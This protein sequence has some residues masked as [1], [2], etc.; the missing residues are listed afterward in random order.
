MPDVPRAGGHLF[1]GLVLRVKSCHLVAYY[2]SY[3][4]QGR[5]QDSRTQDIPSGTR[6]VWSTVL[7]LRHILTLTTPKTRS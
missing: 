2:K 7:L 3:K 1:R 6:A 5:T 4:R